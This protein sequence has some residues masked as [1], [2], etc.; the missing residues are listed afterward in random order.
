M[1]RRPG[2]AAGARPGDTAR[3][4]RRPLASKKPRRR[5]TEQERFI[6]ERFGEDYMKKPPPAGRDSM[7]R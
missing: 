4:R 7:R 1:Q 3:R 2:A 5:L 6:L